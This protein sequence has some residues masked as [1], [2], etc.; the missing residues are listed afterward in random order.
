MR[1]E[2]NDATWPG[3]NT[4]QHRRKAIHTAQSQTTFH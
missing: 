4:D 1:N 3:F 2:I